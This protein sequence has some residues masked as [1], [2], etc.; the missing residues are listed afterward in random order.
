MVLIHRDHTWPY[1]LCNHTQASLSAL[2]P[3]RLVFTKF[4]LPLP[5]GVYRALDPVS[6]SATRVDDG[7]ALQSAT[8]EACP[9]T[10]ATSL[11]SAMTPTSRLSV[12]TTAAQCIPLV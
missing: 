5:H 1:I 12:L 2:Q 6:T 3:S 4:K 10:L 11:F 9:M 7:F 8:I